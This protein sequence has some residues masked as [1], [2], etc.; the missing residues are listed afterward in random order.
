MGFLVL[1]AVGS[2]LGW[3]ASILSRTDDGAGIALNV[4]IGAAGALIVGVL[5]SSESLLVGLSANAL[6]LA[7]ASAT[8]F[9]GGFN[10]ARGTLARNRAG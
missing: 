10:L 3:L 7:M 6:L 5:A 4:A 2:V 9:L 1:I 8:A